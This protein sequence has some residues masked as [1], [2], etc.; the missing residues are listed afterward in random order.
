MG[1]KKILA[2]I[3]NYLF[4]KKFILHGSERRKGG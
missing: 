3:G 2:Q 1:G 4:E